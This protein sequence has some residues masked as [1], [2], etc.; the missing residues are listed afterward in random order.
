[1]A[2]SSKK[3]EGNENYE[4]RRD[5]IF[6]LTEASVCSNI[7]LEKIDNPKLC[8]FLNKH[9]INAGAIPT[10]GQL[11]R[12]YLPQI[13]ELHKMKIVQLV[14]MSDSVSV[15]TDKSTNAKD[16]YVLHILFVLQ[17]LRIPSN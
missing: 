4:R 9:V 12:E 8:A 2:S 1:T 3:L 14:K 13:A 6:D 11:R 16:Q 15:V 10:A 7:P 5:V 17:G